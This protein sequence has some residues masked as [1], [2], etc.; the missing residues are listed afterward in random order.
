[1]STFELRDQDGDVTA[2][3]GY[4][5]TTGERYDL[6]AYVEVIRHGAFKRTISENPDVVLL[7]N[8]D[9]LPLARTSAGT[10]ELEEDEHGLRVAAELDSGDPVVQMLKRKYERGDLDGQMSFAFRVTDQTWSEDHSLRTIR[11]VTLHRG[12]V[13]IVTMGANEATSSALRGAGFT[14]EQRRKRAEQVGDQIRGERGG[15]ITGFGGITP[16]TRPVQRAA[17]GRVHI[18]D[19][20]SQARLDLEQMR[21]GVRTFTPL[22]RDALADAKADLQRMR[23]K[24]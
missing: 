17:A 6:G 15:R 16:R 10:L 14:A 18:P 13:S 20:T 24:R 1:M 21:A 23:A 4:A 22:T 11:S 8:H 5:A 2:F 9:G 12:D 7:V 3:T 19:Y